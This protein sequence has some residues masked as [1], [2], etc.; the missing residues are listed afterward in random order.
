MPAIFSTLREARAY[1]EILLC[2]ALHWTVCAYFWGSDV[3]DNPNSLTGVTGASS[4]KGEA[5]FSTSSL[6]ERQKILEQ[7]DRYLDSLICWSKAFNPFLKKTRNSRNRNNIV[8]ATALHLRFVA[9]HPA[10]AG[11]IFKE[12]VQFDKQ[13]IFLEIISLTQWLID[14]LAT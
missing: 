14:D 4:D 11:S 1:W 6:E 9:S 2:Q 7:Q 5:W 3:R 12:E 13:E 8:G 10:L